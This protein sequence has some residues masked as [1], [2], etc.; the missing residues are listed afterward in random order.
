MRKKQSS[1]K[2]QT[3]TYIMLILASIVIVT[4]G[5]YF[6]YEKYQTYKVNEETEKDKSAK[7]YNFCIED[8]ICITNDYKLIGNSLFYNIQ[9]IQGTK[10]IKDK[11]LKYYKDKFVKNYQKIKYNDYFD[12]K[13]IPTDRG[14]LFKKSYTK[15]FDTVKWSK[16]V[17][18]AEEDAGHLFVINLFTKDDIEIYRHKIITKNTKSSILAD[19]NTNFYYSI[20]LTGKINLTKEIAENFDFITMGWS[21]TLVDTLKDF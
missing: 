13:D 17:K 16:I 14:E 19:S 4:C 21:Q 10:Y 9:V 15:K 12:K 3:F 7:E 20:S 11:Y 5:G 2:L 8:S 6:L 18:L 1:S